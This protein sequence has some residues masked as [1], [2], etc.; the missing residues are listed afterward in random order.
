MWQHRYN[1]VIFAL[2]NVPTS[3]HG[4]N[5]ELKLLFTLGLK[6]LLTFA[7]ADKS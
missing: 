3:G 1:E 4:Q 7:F 5:N 2:L 6:I